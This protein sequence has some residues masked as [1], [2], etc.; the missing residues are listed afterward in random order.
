MSSPNPSSPGLRGGGDV[1]GGA[2]PPGGPSLVSDDLEALKVSIVI[3]GNLADKDKRSQPK[4][5]QLRLSNKKI[6]KLSEAG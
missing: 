2:M 6:K 5:R 4:Y 1:P 3:L